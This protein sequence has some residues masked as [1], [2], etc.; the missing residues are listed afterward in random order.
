M[1]LTDRD[2]IIGFFFFFFNNGVHVQ[3]MTNLYVRLY[4]DVFLNCMTIQM[5]TELSVAIYHHHIYL[6]FLNSFGQT[7]TDVKVQL[8]F[9]RLSNNRST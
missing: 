7:S 9:S 6:Y 1:L 3:E 4:K 2:T 8:C 5:A